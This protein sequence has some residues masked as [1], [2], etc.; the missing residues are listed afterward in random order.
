MYRS[1]VFSDINIVNLINDYNQ[2]SINKNKDYW[3]LKFNSVIYEIKYN[4]NLCIYHF[5]LDLN[6]I[7]LIFNASGLHYYETYNEIILSIYDKNS[8]IIKKIYYLFQS[9]YN[10]WGYNDNCDCK[11]DCNCIFIKINYT[12]DESDLSDLYDL[13]NSTCKF[14]FELL[15]Y[16]SLT[17]IIFHSRFSNDC[18]YPSFKGVPKSL[19]KLALCNFMGVDFNKYKDQ[20]KSIILID[21]SRNCDYCGGINKLELIDEKFI[22]NGKDN[23]L[24]CKHKKCYIKKPFKYGNFYIKNLKL[25][26]NELYDPDDSDDLDDPYDTYDS[27][28]AYDSD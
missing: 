22:L 28:Y 7:K 11:H 23:L 20:L 27:D 9:K 21:L 26:E 4:N 10:D 17:E 3:E 14:I 19:K 5:N 2:F 12:D 6:S 16:T 25:C 8:N 13:Y 24:N 1:N 18:D 15:P